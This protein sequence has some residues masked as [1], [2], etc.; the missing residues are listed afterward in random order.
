[1][2]PMEF[3]NGG[4]WA[5]AD[6]V[7]GSILLEAPESLALNATSAEGNLTSGAVELA[8]TLHRARED[9]EHKFH[10]YAQVLRPVCQLPFCGASLP[11]NLSTTYYF[12]KEINAALRKLAPP[13]LHADL[14]L[15]LSRKWN[16]TM[17]P[18][19]D[20]FNHDAAL[21]KPLQH[22]DGVFQYVAGADIKAGQQ[23]F[24]DYGQ[25]STS[26]WLQYYNMHLNSAP[27]SCKD[28]MYLK[29]PLH[30]ESQ[31]YACFRDDTAHSYDDI[32]NATLD[33]FERNDLAALKGLA[34]WL[35]THLVVV[36]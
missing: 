15:V 32:A 13:D 30:M 25:H 26:G 20:L 12:E 7:A 5:T 33:A 28:A 9:P 3:R 6:I 10:L 1:M 35:D 22:A 8:H 16:N 31:R 34:E 11:V 29:S 19:F 2:A 23:I 36:E 18:V 21:G 27:D 17:L 24:I 4:F 14:S